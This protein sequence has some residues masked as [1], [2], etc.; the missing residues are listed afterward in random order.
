[1]RTSLIFVSLV[2]AGAAHAQQSPPQQPVQQLQLETL[3]DPAAP[4]ATKAQY[5]DWEPGAPAPR[6][7]GGVPPQAPVSAPSDV[8]RV[9]S[10]DY[11]RGVPGDGRSSGDGA[12]YITPPPPVN[13]LSGTDS[14]LTK[15]EA[16]NVATARR[17]IDGSS[18]LADAGAPG[19]DG[20]VVFRYG[21][22]M[23][24]IVCAPLYV[25]SVALQPG[26]VVNNV[27]VGDPVR[28]KITPALS[29]SGPLQVTH[30]TV[31]P[32]DIGLTSNL[33]V[34]TNR[35][36]YLMKL[37]SRKD[38]WMPSIAFS[39]PEDEAAQWAA[40]A[41]QR[42]A[43][44]VATV[45]PETG[46]HLAALD[47]GYRLRGDEPVWRPLRVYNDGTKTY[48]QFPRATQ[49]DELPALVAIGA[50][51]RE[52]MVNY[53]LAGDRFVVD[54]VLKRAVLVSGVGRHQVKV[55]IERTEEG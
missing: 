10:I 34:A 22:A 47:F 28:W 45:M 12:R 33:I 15:R 17:F 20:A 25:C 42:E 44:H 21:A 38:D 52:Q 29:G 35:R 26:E 51:K 36:A 32:V 18:E 9:P 14:T 53:R 6:S 5:V 27:Q 48:I 1:M 8:R 7:V 30:V 24:T 37:V 23:P 40:L 13:L 2:L 11:G 55:R 19:T 39:Y 41:Q 49:A 46:Q 43:E 50:D 31:K 4:P 16:A 54:Q 3:T